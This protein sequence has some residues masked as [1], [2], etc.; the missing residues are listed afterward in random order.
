[1]V[2]SWTRLALDCL[3]PRSCPPC[4][5]AL[6]PGAASDLCPTCT[7]ALVSPSPLSCVRCGGAVAAF[8]AVC[9]GCL[10]RPPAFARAVALGPYRADLGS[11]NVLARTVQCLKYRGHRTLAAPLA[12]LLAAHYPF[13]ADAFLVPVPLHTARLRS[14]G[15]N[16][17]LLLARGLA[18]RRSLGLAP[19]LL[20]R[21]RPT[22]EHARLDAEARRRNV[23]DAFRIRSGPPL[24]GRSV[25]LIDD[26]LTTGATADACARALLAAGARRVDVYTV[27][28]TA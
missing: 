17:S 10:R 19:R 23:R 21:V 18:R 5:G 15:F 8:A 1:M 26:V 11:P 22:E 6:A 25:V 13:A 3:F 24:A 12:E 9:T 2:E 7:A 16:Q 28:R 20:A 4:S 14:R 27:G